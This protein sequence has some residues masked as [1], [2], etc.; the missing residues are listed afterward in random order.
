MGAIKL[1]R[2]KYLDDKG[3][4]IIQSALPQSPKN[5]NGFH[6]SSNA[7]DNEISL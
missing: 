4:T 3:F 5:L 2:S 6:I 1:S 7:T